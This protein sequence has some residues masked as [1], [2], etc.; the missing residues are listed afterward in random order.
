MLKNDQ[1]LN[2]LLKAEAEKRKWKEHQMPNFL[3]SLSA[4]ICDSLQRTILQQAAYEQ[5]LPSPT[6]IPYRC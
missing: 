1:K 3:A 2:K 5:M 6:G 4:Q